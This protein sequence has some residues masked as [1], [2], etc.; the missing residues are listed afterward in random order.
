MVEPGE[1]SK[2]DLGASDQDPDANP[3]GFGNRAKTYKPSDQ[4]YEVTVM[5]FRA[6]EVGTSYDKPIY[7]TSFLVSK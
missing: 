3:L 6:F 1:T 2:P 4:L 5:V 7:Q